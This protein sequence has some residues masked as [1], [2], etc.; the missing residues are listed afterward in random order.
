MGTF[1]GDPELSVSPDGSEIYYTSVAPPPE[2]CVTSGI[3]TVFRVPLDGGAPQAVGH[4]RTT[5]VSGDGVVA[6]SRDYENCR[7]S[8]PGALVIGAA[9][10]SKVLRE[11]APGQSDR[12][13]LLLWGLG[14]STDE[15]LLGFNWARDKV[16]PYLIEPARAASMDD[17]WCLCAAP[18]GAEF[19]GFLGS[20]HEP[21]AS[22]ASGA[23]KRYAENAVV[24][25]PDGSVLRTLFRWTHAIHMVRSDTSGRHFVMTSPTKQLPGGA[26]R[27]VLYRWSRGDTGPTKI[28][29]GIVAAAWVPDPA[30]TQPEIAVVRSDARLDLLSESGEVVRRLGP[31]NDASTVSGS[32]GG[33]ALFVDAHTSG[34]CVTGT[35]PVV[36]RF[37]VSDG[38]R[39]VFS[40]GRFPAVSSQGLVAYEVRCDG[41]T[42]GFTDLR[43]GANSRTNPLADS[44]REAS[45][46]VVG[47]H[48]IDWS[49]DGKS[50]LY[51]VDHKGDGSRFYVGRLWPAVPSAQTTVIP[52]GDY[53]AWE[54][55]SFIDDTHLAVLVRSGGNTEVREIALPDL[56]STAGEGD[57][58]FEVGGRASR[59]AVDSSGE[60]FLVSRVDGE[61]F[62]W[63]RADDVVTRVTGDV[64]ASGWID[65]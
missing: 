27:D 35:A 58:L 32:P 52:L 44:P 46:N 54:W 53:G 38:A 6:F 29:D 33:S 30:P 31:T 39:S 36:E 15:R 56:G 45:D 17:A 34:G 1:R 11:I 8:A 50:L 47:V 23:T 14:W 25:R 22:V 18:A 41:V 48:P 55:A 61:V 59:I 24:L 9:P 12:G 7:F 26:Y 21:V 16:R 49:P 28:R 37:R 5:A 20:S 2:G 64:A 10:A 57:V 40:N 63:Q 65:P 51:L 62:V 60:R 43:T 4:G 13:E 19:Q 3:E 42:L